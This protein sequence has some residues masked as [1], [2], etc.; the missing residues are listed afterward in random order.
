VF[1][2]EVRV[3]RVGHDDGPALP[4]PRLAILGDGDLVHVHAGGDGA[5][6]LLLSAPPLREPAVRWGPFVMNTRE[7]VAQALQEL[8]DGTF[9][10]P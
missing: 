10:K 9:I 5:R 7:E 4:A 8:R 6:F 1:R 2:G 3:G